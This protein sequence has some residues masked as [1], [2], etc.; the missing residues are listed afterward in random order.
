[1]SVKEFLKL[2]NQYVLLRDEE[3]ELI[4]IIDNYHCTITM[5][6]MDEYNVHVGSMTHLYDTEKMRFKK[7]PE[8]PNDTWINIDFNRLI[9]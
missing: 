2:F 5:F 3:K 9:Y 1:M 4:K 6:I 7:D 8:D